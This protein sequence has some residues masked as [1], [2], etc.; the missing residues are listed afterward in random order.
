LSHTEANQGN[1][2]K[3]AEVG[4]EHTSVEGRRYRPRHAVRVYLDEWDEEVLLTWAQGLRLPHDDSLTASRAIVQG[5]ASGELGL[6][7]F[8]GDREL[9]LAYRATAHMRRTMSR[10]HRPYDKALGRLVRTLGVMTR[11][12]RYRERPSIPSAILDDPVEKR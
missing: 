5:L 11:V 8:D 9:D 12:R 7:R 6:V 3:V 2:P 10:L 1:E 4:E